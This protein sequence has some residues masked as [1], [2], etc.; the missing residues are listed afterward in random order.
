MPAGSVTRFDTNNYVVK[1]ESTLSEQEYAVGQRWVSNT[2]AELGL[3]IVAEVENRRVVVSFPAVAERR[4][5]AVNNAPLSRVGYNVGQVIE[6]DEGVKI[7]ITETHDMDGCVVYVGRDSEG[8]LQ[9]IDEINLNSF[10][11]F[12]RPLERMFAGQ[13]D[14]LNAFLIRKDAIDFQHR[15][16]SSEAFGLLGPRAQLLPHQFYIAK[17]VSLMK[18][19]QRIAVIAYSN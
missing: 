19:R 3:G 8:K 5:Y 12:S 1:S 14:K 6:S 11:Q 9:T 15:H 2:E 13:L 7:T 16:A 17:E 18:N 4:T 10:V